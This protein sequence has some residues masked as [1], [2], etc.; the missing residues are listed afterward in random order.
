MYFIM[1]WSLKVSFSL[2]LLMGGRLE[3]KIK[4]LL[5]LQLPFSFSFEI[6]KS[7]GAVRQQASCW[8]TSCP[9]VCKLLS[10]TMSKSTIKLSYY[11]MTEVKHSKAEVGALVLCRDFWCA[12]LHAS[13]DTTS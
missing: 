7:G 1:L 10:P 8:S 9:P 2:A 11:V 12:L 5:W 6:N 13:E 3:K 4:H